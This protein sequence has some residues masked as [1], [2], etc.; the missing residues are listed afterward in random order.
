MTKNPLKA[1]RRPDHTHKPEAPI[2]ALERPQALKSWSGDIVEILNKQRDYLFHEWDFRP[3]QLT[4]MDFCRILKKIT[5]CGSVLELRSK[6]DHGTGEV[7]PPAIHAANFCG[8][9]TI[10]PFCAGRIQDRRK[11]RFREAIQ[12][13]AREFKRAYLVTATIPPV[14]TWREDLDLLLNSWKAFRKM[15]QKRKRPGAKRSN[16]EWGKIKAGLAKVEIKRGEGSSLP[17]CHIHALFFTDEYFDFRV[18]SKEEKERTRGA[19]VSL[20][21]NNGSKIS[22]EWQAAS[23]GQATGLDV[24]L[25][26][27]KP[28]KRFKTEGA[29]EYKARAENWSYSE[30]VFEQSREVLKYATKFDAAPETGAE[31]LFAEDFVNIKCA[32]YG[33]RLFF[34]Y[35]QFRKVGGDDYKGS[36]CPLSSKPIIY[37][38]RWRTDRYSPLVEKARPIFS[39]CDPGPGLSARLKVL[40]RIQGAT[41]RIRKSIF[42]AKRAYLETGYLS[43][44]VFME[45]E[46]L[47][48]GGFTDKPIIL[49]MPAA[50]I[51]APDNITA[52]EEWT[53]AATLAGRTRYN[54]AREDLDLESHFRIIGTAF[55]RREQSDFV[56]RVYWNSQTYE[57]E[58]IRA[59]MEVLAPSSAPPRSRPQ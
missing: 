49:E 51:Q 32:T 21:K 40:N 30:S 37:E 10:C 45:R 41:R 39:N 6:I 24:R 33:R 55:E 34:S 4:K 59:F 27:W 9:H 26:K 48:G 52:W 19:R 18:W 54:Q 57:D 56:N 31:K 43:P 23:G 46:F 28:A 16:G 44:A 35:G 29:A 17:H 53:D 38:T 11:A 25:I 7:S 20:R 50:V 2:K 47:S 22:D 36:E 12:G 3:E 42:G 5:G 58:T 13:A 1:G 8:Q 15:G 14:P